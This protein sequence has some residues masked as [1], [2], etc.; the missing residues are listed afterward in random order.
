[1]MR[2]ALV[3]LI[4]LG[5]A[6][7]FS[8]QTDTKALLSAFQRSIDEGRFEVERDLFKYVLANPS[9][10]D[11]FSLL[12]KLRVRQDRLAE[13]RSLASKALSL[14]PASVSARLTLA[15]VSFLLGEASESR[16][17][18]EP[19]DESA[20]QGDAVRLELARGLSQIGE[21][22]RALIVLEKLPLK[23]R[24]GRA[25]PVRGSCYLESGDRR[26]LMAL[27]PLA[28]VVAKQDAKGSTEF[29]DVLI[30]GGL[31]KDAV[32]VLRIA[33][34]ADPTN[35]AVL[36]LLAKAEVV[37]RNF[38]NARAYLARAEK[39][40]PDSAELYFVLSLVESEQNI[41]ASAYEALEKSL[42]INSNDPKV[43]GQYI[44]IAINVG[45]AGR[46]VRAAEKLLG[47][48]AGNSE[49][50]Y[51]HGIA[52][53]QNKELQTAEASLSKFMDS[54][55]NDERGCIALG[56][57][58]AGRPEKL[59]A[60][61]SQLRKCQE[62]HPK[63]VEAA[64]QLGLL[65]KNAGD[66]PTAI[67][68]FEQT[69]QLAPNYSSALRELGVAHLQSGA[70]GKARPF[71]EKAAAVS[72][73][74]AEAHFQLSRLYNVIGERELAKQHFDIFRKLRQSKSDGM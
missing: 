40:R 39:L 74:D 48:Q 9:D 50:F 3:C 45:Q 15:Q 33:S 7:S 20:I 36:L 24:N 1:M 72:P 73:N 13:A 46:A 19:I 4:L 29:A 49:A 21:C 61:R 18:L 55:P 65:H 56:L 34:V 38:A 14:D 25:L 17:L 53:L 42:S 6:I 68:Y 8:G 23:I 47:L 2:K 57:T 31:A 58:Y 12:A 59:E 66:L 10:A 44:L 11:G 62:I 27:I 5:C 37:L 22:P 32:G 52:A 30:R 70:E 51:L 63:S 26:R 71:L 43:L 60:A 54:R 67:R 16:R 69:I 41:L 35:V 64:F 28:R